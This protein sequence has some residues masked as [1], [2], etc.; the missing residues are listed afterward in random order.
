MYGGDMEV[1]EDPYA[2]YLYYNNNDQLDDERRYISVVA[3]PPPP[4][5]SPSLLMSSPNKLQQ[6]QNQQMSI[7]SDSPTKRGQSSSKVQPSP[8]RVSSNTAM[9]ASGSNTDSQK[10]NQP[11]HPEEEL[12]MNIDPVPAKADNVV[13]LY[14]WYIGLQPT[15]QALSYYSEAVGIKK[16]IQI[17]GTRY[18]SEEKAGSDP[19][20]KR[21]ANDKGEAWHSS[22]I[23]ERISSHLVKSKS[24]KIYELMGKFDETSSCKR[25][26]VSSHTATQFRNGFPTNWADVVCEEA[27]SSDGQKT[28]PKSP[29][30]QSNTRNNATH[31]SPL[32]PNPEMKS[33]PQAP[34]ISQRPKPRPSVSGKQLPESKAQPEARK[35]KSLFRDD[36][37]SSESEYHP[38]SDDAG[39]TSRGKGTKGNTA[40]CDPKNVDML[41]QDESMSSRSSS[42]EVNGQISS[43]HQTESMRSRKHGQEERSEQRIQARKS[44]PMPQQRGISAQSSS[45]PPAEKSGKKAKPIPRELRNLSKTAFGRLTLVQNAIM[46]QLEQ[47]RSE[48]KRAGRQSLPLMRTNAP[49]TP[50]GQIGDNS[51][52][53]TPRS[54]RRTRTPVKPWWEVQPTTKSKSK[55]QAKVTEA[56]KPK[57]FNLSSSSSYR[58]E[59]EEEEIYENPLAH[60]RPVKGPSPEKKSSNNQ[61]SILISSDE[62]TED[63]ENANGPA[64]V[65]E[66]DTLE[67]IEERQI[68]EHVGQRISPANGN[69]SNKR[70]GDDLFGSAEKRSRIDEPEHVAEEPIEEELEGDHPVEYGQE[71]SVDLQYVDDVFIQLPQQPEENGHAHEVEGV[72]ERNE[73]QVEL[74]SN[75]ID[76]LAAIASAQN[77]AEKDEP[78][79]EMNDIHDDGLQQFE[80][81]TFS[82]D[83]VKHKDIEMVIIEDSDDDSTQVEEKD[84]RAVSSTTLPLAKES[85][86][87]EKESSS[88]DAVQMQSES[89]E[90]PIMEIG[91]SKEKDVVVDPPIGNSTGNATPEVS[92]QIGE[93][94]ERAVSPATLPVAKESESR[95]KESSSSDAVQTQSDSEEHPITESEASKEKDVV[96]DL[97]NVNSTGKPID[98]E[99]EGDHPVEHVQEQSDDLQYVNDVSVQLPQQPE[100]NYQA[101]GIEGVG[102]RNEG[103]VEFPSNPIDGLAANEIVQDEINE[104]PVDKDLP[105]DHGEDEKGESAKEVATEE[106]PNHQH[107][108]EKDEPAGEI[109]DVHDD[110]LQQSEM[111]A[112]SNDQVRHKEIEAVVIEDSDDESTQIRE[113]DERAVSAATLPLA[114]ESEHRE[115]ESSSRDAVQ[116]QSDSEEHPIMEIGAS[117]EED[118]VVDPPN[119]EST[120]NA[121][122]EVIHTEPVALANTVS[123]MAQQEGTP[124]NER[125]Y[126]HMSEREEQEVSVEFEG[127][128]IEP[129]GACLFRG[130]DSEDINYDTETREAV[131]E[132]DTGRK[133]DM[134]ELERITPMHLIDPDSQVRNKQNSFIETEKVFNGMDLLERDGIAHTDP[135]QIVVSTDKHLAPVSPP[136]D[137]EMDDDD[138][139]VVSLSEMY[140]FSD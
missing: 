61:A 22:L 136:E 84:E 51:Y 81:E 33:I 50:V 65:T 132:Q 27:R 107:I 82:N 20:G 114:K 41:S 77:I 46:E 129:E 91:V 37:D 111:E 71:Q 108:G 38:S 130:A 15:Q 36:E 55:S 97:P 4:G 123:L 112:F 42:P 69:G 75:P 29:S 94:D 52:L 122:P 72:V 34:T 21:K 58:E 5:V 45:P 40:R 53:I 83:Q 11:I 66:E 79:G 90:H 2:N 18:R 14:D 93:K 76:G 49:Q 47:D 54:S 92:T 59:D 135:H 74:L 78:A 10:E 30:K 88:S 102:E 127:L 70:V 89:E 133:G 60:A 118:V 137:E 16:W 85:E 23:S 128:Q 115:K 24:G 109:D 6:M 32:Q 13:R 125:L 1:W 39:N 110:G 3:P 124:T 101:S 138:E 87:R 117:K 25:K 98:E 26:N 99:M 140:Y 28:K 64:P 44:E 19:K 43:L 119:V 9:V 121:T 96:I 105:V 80:M 103:Q 8:L 57:R 12:Q 139:S 86:H 100:E 31:E 17:Y 68:E 35:K 131:G 48:R 106:L 120:G 62:E 7:A 63:D 113:K 95:E 104:V 116:M 134:N 56:V 73:K 67:L 126:P